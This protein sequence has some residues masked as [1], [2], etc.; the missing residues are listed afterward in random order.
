MRLRLCAGLVLEKVTGEQRE[1]G[2]GALVGNYGERHLFVSEVSDSSFG[3]IFEFYGHVVVLRAGHK[4]HRARFVAAE[5]GVAALGQR[6]VDLLVGVNEAVTREAVIKTV[7]IYIAVGEIEI[8]VMVHP[9]VD[10]E[11]VNT[12]GI[13][14][15]RFRVMHP[16]GVIA[17]ITPVNGNAHTASAGYIGEAEILVAIGVSIVFGNSDCVCSRLGNLQN[18]LYIS[19]MCQLLVKGDFILNIVC[20]RSE[21][22]LHPG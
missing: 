2:L 17:M 5:I 20:L 15:Q 13:G 8:L 7:G 21:S 6:V 9:V 4:E 19:L 22:V 1:V 10:G 14:P 3:V 16:L 12:I 11:R 18:G